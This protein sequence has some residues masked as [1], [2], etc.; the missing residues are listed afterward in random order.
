MTS[1]TKETDDWATHGVILIS[2]YCTTQHQHTKTQDTIRIYLNRLLYL[3]FMV[4]SCQN[5]DHRGGYLKRKEL[6]TEQYVKVNIF[7]VAPINCIFKICGSI[8]YE[9]K[10]NII[11]QSINHVY[12]M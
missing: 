5:L 10:I 1:K 8:I 3:V 4:V 9:R 12:C 11:T 7:T 6:K 2:L